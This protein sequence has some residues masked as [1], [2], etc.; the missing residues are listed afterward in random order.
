VLFPEI[1]RY[2]TAPDVYDGKPAEPTFKKVPVLEFI[3]ASPSVDP[4]PL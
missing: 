4:D 2:L 3:D 1:V